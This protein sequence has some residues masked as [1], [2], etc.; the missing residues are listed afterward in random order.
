M[1]FKYLLI[2]YILYR[3]I[4]I[5]SKDDYTKIIGILLLYLCVREY[6]IRKYG[7]ERKRKLIEG[8]EF[9]EVLSKFNSLF[10]GTWD[11]IFT[12]IFAMVSILN[13]VWTSLVNEKEYDSQFFE[14]MKGELTHAR[15]KL[16][17]ANRYYS[18]Y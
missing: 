1:I 11:D 10:E 15:G 4:D 14:G 9:N 3:V 12:S 16:R 18:N 17:E 8:L 7:K 6:F 5:K 2:F 13:G